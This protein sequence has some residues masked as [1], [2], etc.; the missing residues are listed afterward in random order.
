MTRPV[1]LLV[2][3]DPEAAAAGAFPDHEVITG[4]LPSEPF[5][6]AGT[7]TVWAATVSTPQDVTGVLLAA[8]RGAPTALA[9]DLDATTTARFLDDL[10]RAAE[11]RT[12][13][14]EPS[15]VRL[16]DE[17]VDVLSAVAGG[18]SLDEAAAD[19][20]MSRRTVARRLAEARGALGART[21]VEAIRIAG[22]LGLVEDPTIEEPSNTADSSSA[23]S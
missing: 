10:H 2:T 17:Q 18:R 12:V 16:T 21:T 13:G 8:A 5:D 23:I 20:S 7:A 1:A 9:L 19:L 3:G 6:L 14:G 22:N 15:G 4:T 11:V